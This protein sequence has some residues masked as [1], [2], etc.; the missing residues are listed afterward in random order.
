[1][2]SDHWKYLIVV[3]YLFTNMVCGKRDVGSVEREEYEFPGLTF[4][5][6]NF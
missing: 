6:D 3:P 5:L 2:T 1:M 4:I